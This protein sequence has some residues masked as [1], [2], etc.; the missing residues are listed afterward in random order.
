MCQENI[1]TPVAGPL[2]LRLALYATTEGVELPVLRVCRAKMPV[3]PGRF[4][5]WP[6]EM[7]R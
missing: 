2:V 3:L 4:D 1:A 5:G 7:G 6:Q